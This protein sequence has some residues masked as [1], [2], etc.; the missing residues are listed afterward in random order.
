[1]QRDFYWELVVHFW[2]N[3]PLKGN[4]V[5]TPVSRFYEGGEN[6]YR[7]VSIQ[8]ENPPSREDFLEVVNCTLWMRYIWSEVPSDGSL[9]EIAKANPWP[10]VEEGYKSASVD[11]FV[12]GRSVGR[13]TIDRQL[14]W[15]NDYHQVPYVDY[16]YIRQ[17]TNRCKEKEQA[18]NF[19]LQ[20]RQLL[21]ERLS[22]FPNASEKLVKQ[23]IRKILV[24]KGLLKKGK[25]KTKAK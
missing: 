25:A 1:M 12:E 14:I 11:L 19:M 7:P 8:F 15:V 18:Y 22:S 6:E 23:E 20:N 17:V 5:P 21:L 13:L 9:V 3:L 10:R 24:E 2:G 16:D 4:K